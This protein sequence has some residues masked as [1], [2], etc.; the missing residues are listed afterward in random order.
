MELNGT[1]KAL[2]SKY[3]VRG[4]IDQNKVLQDLAIAHKAKCNKLDCAE[5]NI[6]FNLESANLIKVGA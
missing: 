2:M 1:T 6:Y 3:I 5:C 4:C